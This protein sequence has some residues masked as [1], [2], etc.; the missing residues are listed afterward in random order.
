MFCFYSFIKM[1][2]PRDL[3]AGQQKD[4]E[5]TKQLFY[6]SKGD[7]QNSESIL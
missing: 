4:T 1:M 6:I 7:K 5:S 2:T 3:F